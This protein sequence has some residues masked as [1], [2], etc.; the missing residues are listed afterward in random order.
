MNELFNELEKELAGLD[1]DFTDW[2]IKYLQEHKEKYVSDLCFINRY[3][4]KDTILEIGS[5]PLHLTYCLTRLGYN[6]VGLDIDPDRAKHFITNKELTVIK[7]DIEK[8][9]LPFEDGAFENILFLEILE[10]LRIDPLF[11]LREINRVLAKNGTMILSTPNLYSLKKIINFNRGRGF[12]N[13]YEQYIKLHELGHMGHIREYSTSEVQ[14]F[15]ENTGFKVIKTNYMDYNSRKKASVLLLK[16]AY[17]IE[18]TWKPYQ[19]II[20]RSF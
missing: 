12:N 16:I 6:I 1:S 8:E 11:T 20:A 13:P 5:F 10:H 17:L 9:K 15:L 14:Q 18:P 7:C 4:S 3:F 19:V 2:S